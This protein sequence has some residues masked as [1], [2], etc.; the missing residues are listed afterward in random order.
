MNNQMYATIVTALMNLDDVQGAQVLSV[1]QGLQNMSS[2]VS[3]PSPAPASKLT[4]AEDEKSFK[5]TV[6]EGKMLWQEDFCT[7]SYADKQYRLYITCPLK[8]EKGEKVRYAIKAGAKKDYNAKFGGDFKAGKIFWVFPD[9]A[10][11]MKYI[12]SRKEYA[13]KKTA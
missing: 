12:E 2:A 6:I 1:V 10:T 3:S 4:Y 9:K 8:G 11:A 5:P 7:V 13:A